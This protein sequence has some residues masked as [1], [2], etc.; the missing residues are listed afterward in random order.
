MS[1]YTSSYD[2]IDKSF[3]QFIMYITTWLISWSGSNEKHETVSST[4]SSQTITEIQNFQLKLKIT[5]T[6]NLWVNEKTN[7]SNHAAKV[8]L[9]NY[10]KTCHK[11]CLFCYYIF[12]NDKRHI[13]AFLPSLWHFKISKSYLKEI[14]KQFKRLFEKTYYLLK[15]YKYLRSLCTHL[16]LQSVLMSTYNTWP[17]VCGPPNKV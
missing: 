5:R 8:I 9:I 4:Y 15:Y 13:H 7:W 12:G 1:L 17:K 11:L 3:T 14:H 6:N 16:L 2:F 10:R